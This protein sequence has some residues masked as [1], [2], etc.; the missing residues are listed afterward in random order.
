[1]LWRRE[2]ASAGDHTPAIESIACH[3]TDCSPVKVGRHFVGISFSQVMNQ[4]VAGSKLY[5]DMLI[6]TMEMMC[7]S[8]LLIK[9]NWTTQHYVPEDRSFSVLFSCML[10]LVSYH[11]C[12]KCFTFQ[13]MCHSS[14]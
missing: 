7:L 2:F 4:H 10:N 13:N 1:M 12:K 9:F 6:L 11:Q 5:T 3:Y 8:E 14:V